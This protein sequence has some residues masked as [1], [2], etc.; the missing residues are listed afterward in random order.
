MPTRGP[1]LYLLP[2]TDELQHLDRFEV[3]FNRQM[4]HAIRWIYDIHGWNGVDIE[5]RIPG[6]KASVW[7]RYG[8]PGYKK[9]RSMHV[10][11]ALSWVTKVSMSALLYGDKI[12]QYWPGASREKIRLFIFSGMLE[13]DDFCFL[14]RKIVTLTNSHSTNI[15]PQLSAL[16]SLTDKVSGSLLPPDH[17]DI[18]DFGEDYYRSIA[19]M[20][21]N[22]RRVNHFSITDMAIVLNVSDERY[23][24]FE[25]SDNPPKHLSLHL[26]A[27][28]K[29]AFKIPD[30]VP[31]VSEMSRYPGFAQ[32][33]NIHQLRELLLIDLLAD[34]SEDKVSFLSD[35]TEAASELSKKLF[36]ARNNK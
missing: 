26:A 32:T 34:V 25:N 28:I 4:S 15:T 1:S 30:T 24:K 14:V 35:F 20:L 10:I 27:R 6:V 9:S 21:Q 22:F 8:Q 19:L 29:L 2:T 23:M 31:F 12:A 16:E 36:G 7:Q 33:R 5:K 11:A 3:H 17:I 13:H 18:G